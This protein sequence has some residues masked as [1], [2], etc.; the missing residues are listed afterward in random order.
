MTIFFVSSI[1]LYIR[2][3]VKYEYWQCT[4]SS[5]LVRKRIYLVHGKACRIKQKICISLA[6]VSVV[7]NSSL[8]C[9]SFSSHL[10]LCVA[11]VSCI[12]KPNHIYPIMFML[13]VAIHFDRACDSVGMGFASI[14]CVDIAVLS[15]IFCRLV[16][17]RSDVSSILGLQF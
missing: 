11:S 4:I 12:W 14:P 16:V 17:R 10:P 3:C 13:K 15:S 9:L 5:H 6:S 1:K 8:M 2:I 7:M